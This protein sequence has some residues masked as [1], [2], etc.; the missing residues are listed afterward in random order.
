MKQENN[1]P[2]CYQYKRNYINEKIRLMAVS[3]GVAFKDAYNTLYSEFTKQSGTDIHVLYRTQEGLSKMDTLVAM[4]SEHG[5]LTQFYKI[6]QSNYNDF[7]N[8]KNK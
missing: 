7:K 5:F 4:E 2:F 6:I 3:Y 1:I 8:D